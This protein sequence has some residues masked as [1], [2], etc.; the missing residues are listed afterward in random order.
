M[1]ASVIHTNLASATASP[2]CKKTNSLDADQ[3][4]N[5][6]QNQHKQDKQAAILGSIKIYLWKWFSKEKIFFNSHHNICQSNVFLNKQCSVGAKGYK[7]FC[8]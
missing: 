8:S 4:R 6:R 1:R 5:K 3:K 7:K 2:L